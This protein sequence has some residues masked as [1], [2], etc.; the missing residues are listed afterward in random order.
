MG[1]SIDTNTKIDYLITFIGKHPELSGNQIYNK[2][3]G[4]KYG[5]RKKDFY[6]IYRGTKGLPKVST[7]KYIKS[8]PKKYRENI[9]KK[10]EKEKSER[11]MID[12]EMEEK[13][14][15]FFEAL[16]FMVFR[17]ARRKPDNFRDLEHNMFKYGFNKGLYPSHKQVNLAWN[18]LKKKGLTYR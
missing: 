5:I 2:F 9:L 4:S 6:K 11:M 14:N 16:E 8:I 13:Y 18:Y 3:K 15:S 12:E 17:K 1:G 10:I 7:E